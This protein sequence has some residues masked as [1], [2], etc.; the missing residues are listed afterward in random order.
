M[1]SPGH[2]E[3]ASP[4]AAPSLDIENCSQIKLA[5]VV[6]GAGLWALFS[7]D[8]NAGTA[9]AAR[10]AIIAI[11]TSNSISVNAEKNFFVL[12]FM[13][14]FFCFLRVVLR[15]FGQRLTSIAFAVQVNRPYH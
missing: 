4:V 12:I 7:A 10:I 6:H 3:L 1:R 8:V 9:R 11:T 5:G 14:V 2:A 13:W 15:I